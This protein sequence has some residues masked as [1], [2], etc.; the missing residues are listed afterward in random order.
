MPDCKEILTP[1]NCFSLTGAEWTTELIL[2]KET[3]ALHYT[4]PVDSEAELQSFLIPLYHNYLTHPP[5]LRVGKSATGYSL[6]ADEPLKKGTVVTEYLGEWSTSSKGSPYRFGNY[7]AFAED[8]FPN[9]EAF[10]LYGVDNV[11]LRILFVALEDLAPGQL[12]TI[13]YGLNHSIKTI[14]RVEYGLEAMYDFFTQNPLQELV[15]KI[16]WA[17]PQNRMDLGW[18]EVL[19]FENRVAKLQYLFHTPSAFSYLFF[20]GRDDLVTST[21]DPKPFFN[22]FAK[23]DNRYQLLSYKMNPT[24]RQREVE[25]RFATLQRN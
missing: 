13:N 2:P 23:L 19:A 3:A 9:L 21:L 15:Q 16:R 7:A 6:Y 8:G 17:M 22:F 14:E 1:S 20:L 24:P 10:Y 5:R 11:P 4:T 18:E 12:L 25:E